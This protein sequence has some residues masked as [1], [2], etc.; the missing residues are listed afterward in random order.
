MRFPTFGLLKR[1]T[2][3][4]RFVYW[5]APTAFALAK[6]RLMYF[7]Y[8]LTQAPL[9]PC[10]VLGARGQQLIYAPPAKWD[11]FCKRQGSW[12][13]AS[14]RRGATLLVSDHELPPEFADR[15]DARLEP[16]DFAPPREASREDFETLVHAEAYTNARPDDWERVNRLDPIFF[17]IFFRLIRVWRKG[18]N[19]RRHWIGHRANHANFLAKRLTAEIGGALVPY[20]VT[21]NEGVCSS[22]AEFFNLIAPNDR[23]LVRACPGAITFAG[24]QRNAFY[25]VQPVTLTVSTQSGTSSLDAA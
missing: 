4:P 8:R 18:D 12:Y 19:F 13:R 7:G 9:T 5:F 2:P 20:S 25:D 14:H 23:K 3:A 16:S 15:L 24:A 17:R 10:Q 11:G 22:C 21:G 6:E 1:T